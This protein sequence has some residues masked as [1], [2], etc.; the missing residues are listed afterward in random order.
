[1]ILRSKTV[2]YYVLKNK[3]PEIVGQKE[4]EKE[5]YIMAAK[6]N[7]TDI[8]CSES[9]EPTCNLPEYLPENYFW[10]IL[11]NNILGKGYTPKL[12]S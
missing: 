6:C 2:N 10:K 12:K 5:M 4:E 11:R 7:Q 9:P 1:M 8:L 3:L